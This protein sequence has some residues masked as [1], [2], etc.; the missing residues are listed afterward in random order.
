MCKKDL[1]AS[2]Y[3]VGN[4]NKDGLFSYCRDCHAKRGVYQKIAY[5]YKVA[6]VLYYKMLLEQKGLCA[7]CHRPETGGRLLSLDHNHKTNQV[8]QLL[9]RCCNKM[10]GC[11]YEDETIL[12]AAIEYLRKHNGNE[13]LL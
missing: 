12:M 1:P 6:S 7:I 2:M 11:A 9:C 3:Q 4:K 13:I 5:R 10:I 8:R